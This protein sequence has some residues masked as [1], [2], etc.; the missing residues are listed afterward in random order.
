MRKIVSQKDIEQF[1]KLYVS[2]HTVD[3]ISEITG[4]CRACISTRLR[5]AGINFVHQGQRR[6]ITNE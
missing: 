5:K 3:Q 2:G 1:V 4:W 6:E